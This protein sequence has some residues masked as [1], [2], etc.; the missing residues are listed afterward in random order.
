MDR[1]QEILDL[2]ATAQELTD[3][4]ITD[5]RTELRDLAKA[6]E[7]DDS[8]KAIAD[9]EGI[10]SGLDAIVAEETRRTEAKAE[11]AERKKA[12]ADRI[13]AID[14][15]DEDPDG[16][17]ADAETP[18]DEETAEEPVAVAAAATAEPKVRISNVNARR[19][20]RQV[21]APA[22]APA[23][24]W[25]LTAAANAPGVPYGEKLADS[26]SIG[27]AFSKAAELALTA[28]GEINVV[29]ASA[30][31]P[32]ARDLFGD[33]RTL[34]S[35]ERANETRIRRFAGTEAIVASGGSPSPAAVRYDIPTIGSDARPLRDGAM[36]RFGADRGGVK[37]I[38]IPTLTASVI[39]G[40]GTW[41]EANDRTPASPTT[42][43]YFTVPAP[44]PAETL[45]DAITMGLRYGNFR[46]NYFKEQI[47]EYMN[48]LGVA[49]ARVAERKLLAAQ[50]TG[51]TALT[52]GQTLGT[53][54]DLLG[55]LDRAVA[56]ARNNHRL[57]RNFPFRF[58]A[59]EW[60]L[61]QARTDLARELPGSADE[62]LAVA[63][64]K[65][66]SFLESRHVNVTWVMEG[67]TGQDF[68]AQAAGA[69]QGWPSTAVTLFYPE[70]SWLFLD[71][72]SLD[73]GV[74]RDSTLIGTNDVGFF[75]ETFEQCAFHGAFSWA[76][77]FDTCPDG[78]TSATVDINPCTVGS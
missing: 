7:G 16:D 17:P 13:A 55:G 20:A 71:G 37:L 1:I 22:A 26:E 76:L 70:G 48:L 15:A 9:L 50:V 58:V 3:E 73:L 31:A 29:V 46:A 38:P 62:R 60:L 44:V 19:P 23:S 32:S 47:D 68:G 18:A 77:T 28:R 24:G 27:R 39:A 40:I 30:G 25:A 66:V 5:L 61:D 36:V 45:V 51:S 12:L 63:E 74:Y 2:L 14:A 6:L 33:D 67:G 78:S 21:A 64:A 54:R 41:T 52:V 56:I 34:G 42:K 69:L 53:M 10:L 59:P 11:R 49:H 4:Q 35:D 8:D 65:I 43:P 72:G 75:A 57:P